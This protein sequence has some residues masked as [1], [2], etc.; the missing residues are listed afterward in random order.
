MI[1]GT[2]FNIINTNILRFNTNKSWVSN[3]VAKK[4]ISVVD[5]Y[6]K[7]FIDKNVDAKWDKVFIP[8]GVEANLEKVPGE[9]YDAVIL[10]LSLN[11]A[12]D[13][14]KLIKESKRVLKKNGILLCAVN[15]I[16]PNPNLKGSLWGFTE[17]ACKYAFSKYFR[18][19]K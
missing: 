8:L 4:R 17:E 11:Y 12:K 10:P 18:N 19:F 16:A 1:K 6:V 15:A 14:E 13:P 3:Q 5:Y 7:T 9:F 2:V